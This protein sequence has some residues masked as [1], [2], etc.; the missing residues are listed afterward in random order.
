[1]ILQRRSSS[2]FTYIVVLH[3]KF[4]NYLDRMSTATRQQQRDCDREQHAEARA[5]LT[6]LER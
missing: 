2:S 4:Q 6:D 3:K 5:R 1:M